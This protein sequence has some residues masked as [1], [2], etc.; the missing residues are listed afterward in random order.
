[1]SVVVAFVFIHASDVRVTDVTIFT[2]A[3]ETAVVVVAVGV[4]HSAVGFTFS[5]SAFVDI[6][7]AGFSGDRVD[8]VLEAIGALAFIRTISIYANTVAWLM[9]RGTDVFINLALIDVPTNS[10]PTISFKPWR[11]LTFVSPN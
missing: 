10:K 1:M 3:I 7:A 6:S 2:A 5:V 11:T 9:R 8:S 4:Y